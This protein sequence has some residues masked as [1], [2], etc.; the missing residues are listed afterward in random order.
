MELI[1]NQINLWRVGIKNK[2]VSLHLTVRSEYS[3]HWFLT[4]HSQI[5]VFPTPSFLHQI[6]ETVDRDLFCIVL[7][8]KHQHLEVVS[9]DYICKE[10]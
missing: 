1:L 10:Q 8:Y 9:I 7:P 4:L 6:D 5:P 3:R 2:A